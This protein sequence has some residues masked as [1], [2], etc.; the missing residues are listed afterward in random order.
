MASSRAPS[1]ERS[2]SCSFER[3]KGRIP[4]TWLTMRSRRRPS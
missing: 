1:P 3:R 2:T 4:R